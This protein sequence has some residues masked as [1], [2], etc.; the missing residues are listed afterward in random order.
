MASAETLG[1]RRG[2]H[3]L[4]H[5]DPDF[6]RAARQVSWKPTGRLTLDAPISGCAQRAAQGNSPSSHPAVRAAVAKPVRRSN[7]IAAKLYEL[8]ERRRSGRRVR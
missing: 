7:A 5:H 1:Q 8:G 2:V 4:R 3:F 6:A